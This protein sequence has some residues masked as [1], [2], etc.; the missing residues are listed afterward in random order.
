[1]PS[2]VS[3]PY[4]AEEE[5]AVVVDGEAVDGVEELLVEDVEDVEDAESRQ[6]GSAALG[7][8]LLSAGFEDDEIRRR[9]VAAHCSIWRRLT[10]S[11]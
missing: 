2:S 8:A 6:V 4:A 10:K 1:M 7:A 3:S 9:C 5:E 11:A